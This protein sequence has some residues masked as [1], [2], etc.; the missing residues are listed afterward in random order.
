MQFAFW[1]LFIAPLATAFFAVSIDFQRIV[2][3]GFVSDYAVFHCRLMFV[4]LQ[5]LDLKTKRQKAHRRRTRRWALMLVVEL[6]CLYL[7]GVIYMREFLRC[8]PGSRRKPMSG[9]R[10][11]LLPGMFLHNE[12]ING[13]KE[14]MDIC[15][16]I[17][18]KDRLSDVHLQHFPIQPFGI[19][20]GRQ[21][22]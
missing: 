6:D 15:V 2:G 3:P 5:L 1:K 22:S 12:R 7:T 11:R 9:R 16:W 20:D 18:L 21:Q 4:S 13:R 8:I 19:G 17:Q 10:F 14:F